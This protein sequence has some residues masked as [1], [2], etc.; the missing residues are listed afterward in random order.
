MGT[1]GHSARRSGGYAPTATVTLPTG[2]IV[3]LNALSATSVGT[4]ANLDPIT[5]WNNDGTGGASYSPTQSNGTLKPTY[6]ASRAALN[7]HP[8]LLFDGNDYLR[9]TANP[10]AANAAR[11]MFFVC[12]IPATLSGG[13][14]IEFNEAVGYFVQCAADTV[15]MVNNGGGTSSKIASAPTAGFAI[16]DVSMDGTTTH[17]PTIKINGVAQT[18]SQNT[19]T[20]VGTETDTASYYIG[21]HYGAAI[22]RILI[23][24]SVLSAGDA[25]NAYTVLSTE[26][27]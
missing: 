18:V 4:P 13:L 26:W 12:E 14:I 21:Y 5:T 11:H 24:P 3:D 9:A 8:G 17:L 15:V 23:Y 19:G 2:A 7:N 16:I 20:G 22:G 25:A 1:G 10:I 6:Y 27:A